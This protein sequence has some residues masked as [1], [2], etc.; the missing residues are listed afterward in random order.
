MTKVLDQI[1]TSQDVKKLDPEELEK[2][3]HEIRG[4][5]ISTV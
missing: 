3:C 4:E 2:L 1:N 5:I